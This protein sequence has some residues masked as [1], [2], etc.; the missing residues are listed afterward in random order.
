MIQDTKVDKNNI[1]AYIIL[2]QIEWKHD[3]KPQ[4][5]KLQAALEQQQASYTK[6]NKTVIYIN[7]QLIFLT[8]PTVSTLIRAP[9]FL[10]N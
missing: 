5:A 3:C 10:T 7:D 1:M 2:V 8:C 9:I 4:K 6:E